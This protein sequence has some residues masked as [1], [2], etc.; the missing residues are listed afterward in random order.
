[1]GQGPAQAPAPE[2]RWALLRSSDCCSSAWDWC[3]RVMSSIFDVISSTSSP[4]SSPSPHPP[5]PFPFLFLL[6]LSS[7]LLL[8]WL[9]SA[10]LVSTWSSFTSSPSSSSS[11][12]YTWIFYK[13]TSIFSE[14]K[15]LKERK[16]TND[17]TPSRQLDGVLLLR[18]GCPPSS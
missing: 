16:R 7:L 12:D 15:T 8:C 4:P 1:M 3:R 2:K 17:C 6:S 11:S 10:G 13:Y 9:H 18:L 14:A 5:A